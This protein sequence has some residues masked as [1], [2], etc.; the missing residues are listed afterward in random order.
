[1][2]L[3]LRCLV[4]L[5]MVGERMYRAGL[6]TFSRLWVVYGYSRGRKKIVTHSTSIQD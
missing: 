3:G 6:E 2:Y 4:A 5:Y 1:M